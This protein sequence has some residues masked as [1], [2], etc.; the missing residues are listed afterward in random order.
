MMSEVG[1]DRSRGNEAGEPKRAEKGREGTAREMEAM[2]S[3]GVRTASA[4]E[5]MSEHW[6]EWRTV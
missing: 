2:F 5:R 3:K 6:G 4:R 1:T